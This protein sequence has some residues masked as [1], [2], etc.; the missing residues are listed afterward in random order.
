MIKVRIRPYQKYL[1]NEMS[2]RL[3][4]VNNKWKLWITSKEIG[5][6]ED[7]YI[8]FSQVFQKNTMKRTFVKLSNFKQTGHI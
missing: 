2:I 8:D 6:N 1:Q 4:D 5:K 7:N 3:I